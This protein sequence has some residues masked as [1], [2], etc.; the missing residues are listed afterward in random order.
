MIKNKAGMRN[1]KENS[2]TFLFREVGS[3]PNGIGYRTYD[4]FNKFMQIGSFGKCASFDRATCHAHPI[5]HPIP[6]EKTP[7]PQG[8]PHRHP[9]DVFF[10]DSFA[11]TW[12]FGQSISLSR[13]SLRCRKT[14]NYSLVILAVPL[15]ATTMQQIIISR[16]QQLDVAANYKCSPNMTAVVCQNNRL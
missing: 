1:C 8:I 10:F 16:A 13:R 4:G 11:Q 7:S 9:T 14:F 15:P 2:V 3:I 5:H 6:F 12:V